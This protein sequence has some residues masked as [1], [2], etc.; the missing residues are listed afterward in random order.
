MPRFPTLSAQK[1]IKVLTQ[2]GF[3]HYRTS[4]SHHIFI[5]KTDQIRVSVPVHKGHD[6]GRGLTASILKDAGIGVD[7]LLKLL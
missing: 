3:I 2:K 7:E 4:G 5:R 6:L 1:L